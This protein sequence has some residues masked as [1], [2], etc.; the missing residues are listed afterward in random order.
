V[1]CLSRIWAFF[2]EKG[3]VGDVRRAGQRDE[4][5]TAATDQAKV[6]L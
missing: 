1:L 5:V 3:L 6:S 4:I 2:A